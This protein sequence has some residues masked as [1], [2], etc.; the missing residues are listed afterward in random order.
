MQTRYKKSV[1]GVPH[2]DT[3]QIPPTDSHT[4]CSS[5]LSAVQKFYEN[6]DN[7]MRFNDW[8]MSRDTKT[9]KEKTQ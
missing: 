8:K 2:I 4:L 9:K 5:F 3:A 1:G 7:L 6:P